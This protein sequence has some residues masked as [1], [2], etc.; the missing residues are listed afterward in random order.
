MLK[1]L[2]LSDFEI[3]Q[4]EGLGSVSIRGGYGL[5]EEQLSSR[6]IVRLAA[7]P[8]QDVGVV[9]RRTAQWLLRPFRT[10]CRSQTPAAS[11]ELLLS[12]WRWGNLSVSPWFSIL[13]EE[14]VRTTRL[15]GRGPVCLVRADV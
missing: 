14:H 2:G 15:V 10:P 5:T 4:I 7:D 6:A 12:E 1:A 13:R 3:E 8:P 11:E 9:Q